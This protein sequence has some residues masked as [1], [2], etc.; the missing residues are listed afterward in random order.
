[1]PAVKA[2][3]LKKVAAPLPLRHLG[4]AIKAIV[5]G[6]AQVAGKHV[7]HAAGSVGKSV[8]KVVKGTERANKKGPWYSRGNIGK[9]MLENKKTTGAVTTGAGAMGTKQ[10]FG[11]DDNQYDY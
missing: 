9:K 1:M 4:K 5:G 3:K 8:G 2:P 6:K 10:I 7:G 11:S